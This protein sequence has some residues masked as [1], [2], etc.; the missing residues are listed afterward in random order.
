[1]QQRKPASTAAACAMDH[2][3]FGMSL[4]LGIAQDPEMNYTCVRL[5][6]A[7]A[8]SLT[9]NHSGSTLAPSELFTVL[10]YAKLICVSVQSACKW[11]EVGAYAAA[12][13]TSYLC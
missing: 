3:A 1:M 8:A 5:P 12:P 9:I 4:M 7:S 6:S 11:P 13:V 2:N 10:A